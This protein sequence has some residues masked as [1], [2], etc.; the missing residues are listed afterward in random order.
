MSPITA[1]LLVCLVAV[2]SATVP[3]IHEADSSELMHKFHPE[4][5]SLAHGVHQLHYKNELGKEA[6]LTCEPTTSD[7]KD[8]AHKC[9]CADIAALQCQIKTLRKEVDQAHAIASQAAN[10]H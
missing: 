8:P 9:G 5:T 3:A 10:H 6:C 4:V 7:P 1:V 2:A